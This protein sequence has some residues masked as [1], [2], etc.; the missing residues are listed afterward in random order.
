MV[1]ILKWLY[2]ILTGRYVQ[3]ALAWVGILYLLITIRHWIRN[4]HAN[5]ETEVRKNQE[6]YI[7]Q[8]NCLGVVAAGIGLLV[9]SVLILMIVGVILEANGLSSGFACLTPLLVIAGIILY[10]NLRK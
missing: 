5:S 1:H 4:R 10:I 6:I 2:H 3:V 9:L 7:D 8:L